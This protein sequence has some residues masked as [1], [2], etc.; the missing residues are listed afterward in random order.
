MIARDGLAAWV[1]DEATLVRDGRGEPRYWQGV[2]SDVTE[3]KAL[4]G[5]LRHRALLEDRLG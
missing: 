3:R 5:R 2:I 4:E 1:R